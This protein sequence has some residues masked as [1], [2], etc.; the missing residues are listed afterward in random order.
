MSRAAL[1]W[2]LDLLFPGCVSVL[3]AGIRGAP[4]VIARDPFV[5]GTV[6]QVDAAGATIASGS[7]RQRIAFD[8]STSW[9]GTAVNGLREGDYLEAIGVWDGDVLRASTMWVNVVRV[10]GTITA[11]RG[12]VVVLESAS[13]SAQLEL[14]EA[15]LRVLGDV[16]TIHGRAASILAV[17][18]GPHLWVL[19]LWI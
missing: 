4:A 7:A 9:D 6:R 11:R 15:A 12:D 2:L 19:E 17:P 10:S 5:A 18:Q 8:A 14:N 16:S 1:P 13:G 3:R